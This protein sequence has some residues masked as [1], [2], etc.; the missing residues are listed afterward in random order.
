MVMRYKLP[1]ADPVHVVRPNT[2]SRM[3][4][5]TKPAIWSADYEFR[6]KRLELMPMYFFLSACEAC[7]KL[8]AR[9][10]DWETLTR[11][12]ITRRQRSFENQPVR[13]VNVPEFC[14][15]HGPGQP[16]YKYGFYHR[17]RTHVAWRVPVFWGKLPRAPHADAPAAERG[18]FAAFMMA[19]FRPYRNFDDIVRTALEAATEPLTEELVWSLME[20]EYL[21]WRRNDIN[22]KTAEYW[23][24]EPKVSDFDSVGW[25]ACLVEEKLRNYETAMRRHHSDSMHTPASLYHLPDY[26]ENP[27]QSNASEDEEDAESDDSS[28]PPDADHAGLSSRA[29]EFCHRVRPSRIFIIRR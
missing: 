20:V 23:S 29:A 21:R 10:L 14:L 25:W 9:S 8:D 5:N 12:G 16:I 4:I 1:D 27:L 15:L 2:S 24:A 3:G 18:F 13:S 17:L 6:N 26:T 19:L 28:E 22:A 11:D 7:E